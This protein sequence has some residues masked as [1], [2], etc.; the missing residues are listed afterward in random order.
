MGRKSNSVRIERIS[1]PLPGLEALRVEAAEQDFR[2]LDRLISDWDEGRNTFSADGETLLGAF[3]HKQLIAVGGLNK[4][5]YVSDSATAR[6]R[7]LYVLSPWR[8]R[9]MG[10]S[11]VKRL[12]DIAETTFSRVRLRTDTLEAASFYENCGFVRIEDETASHCW[13]AHE[14]PQPSINLY[15]CK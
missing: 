8:R 14:N 10:R 7:H 2:F 12:L 11:L 13:K 6:I 1:L 3:Y 15:S 4:D 9:G 5:P